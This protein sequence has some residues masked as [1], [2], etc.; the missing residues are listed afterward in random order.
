MMEEVGGF[1]IGWVPLYRAECTDELSQNY[2]LA[3]INS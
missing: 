1:R 2:H 3:D